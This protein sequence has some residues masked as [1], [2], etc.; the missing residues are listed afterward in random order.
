MRYCADP[1]VVQS[2][3]RHHIERDNER[4]PPTDLLGTTPSRSR[5]GKFNFFYTPPPSKQK[6]PPLSYN[7]LPGCLYQ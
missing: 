5:D 3:L 6:T 2:Y 1:A 7:T 4:L